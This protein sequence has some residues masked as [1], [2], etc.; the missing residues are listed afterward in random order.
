VI[1]IVDYGL[2]NILAIANIYKRLDLPVTVASDATA[3][4]TMLFTGADCD[5]ARTRETALG[6]L[7][8]RLV[9]GPARHDP[10]YLHCSGRPGR[11]R[12]GRSGDWSRAA[13]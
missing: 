10:A 5:P 7:R 8:R 4:A 13:G 6:I 1:T 2:G 12:I 9:L 3:G 11:R